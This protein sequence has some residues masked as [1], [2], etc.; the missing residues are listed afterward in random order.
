MTV[1]LQG[2]NRL[3]LRDLPSKEALPCLEAFIL[4]HNN[5]TDDGIEHLAEFLIIQK[6]LKTISIE[7]CLHDRIQI[8]HLFYVL[9]MKSFTCINIKRNEPLQI[10]RF[11]EILWALRQIAF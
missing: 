4:N 5:L 9:G 1:R 6:R 3:G 11:S 2:L 7:D 10:T 8:Q